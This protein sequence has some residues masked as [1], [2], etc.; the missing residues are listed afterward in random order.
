MAALR[1]EEW[2]LSMIARPIFMFPV[3]MAA[4]DSPQNLNCQVAIR[5]AGDISGDNTDLMASRMA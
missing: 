3:S 2:S 1:I 4:A 5:H